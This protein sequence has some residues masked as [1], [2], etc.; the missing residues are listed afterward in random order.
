MEDWIGAEGGTDLKKVF[1]RT[2][3]KPIASA[4]NKALFAEESWIWFRLNGSG[5]ISFKNVK[6][7]AL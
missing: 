4:M 1:E 2:E 3:T 7:T 6:V 5:S